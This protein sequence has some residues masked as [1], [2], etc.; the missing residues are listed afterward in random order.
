MLS[1]ALNTVRRLE[2]RLK[3][4]SPLVEPVRHVAWRA[5]DKP[6]RRTINRPTI[7]QKGT[8]DYVTT[9]D[10]NHRDVRAA[11]LDGPY[12]WNVLSTYKYRTV[13]GRRQWEVGTFVHDPADT[14]WQH[15]VY[16]FRAPNGQ[17]DVYAHREASVRSPKAHENGD[18][19]TG[20]PHGLHDLFDRHDLD[21]TE[22]QI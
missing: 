21:Y 22:R 1:R 13:D 18:R 10:A 16:T 6:L 12:Q 8:A 11:L 17:T 7:R 4:F 2:K 14:G 5:A 9:V 20:D 19:V 15:H 3:Q